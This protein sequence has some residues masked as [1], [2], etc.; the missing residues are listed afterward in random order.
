M[1]KLQTLLEETYNT[2]QACNIRKNILAC[3]FSVHNAINLHVK[4]KY[5]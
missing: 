5:V 2:I 1:N 4:Y 3:L